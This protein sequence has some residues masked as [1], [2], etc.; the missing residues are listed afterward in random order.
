MTNYVPYRCGNKWGYMD[1]SG[2]KIIEAKYDS[3][4]LFNKGFAVV[5]LKNRFGLIDTNGVLILPLKFEEVNGYNDE[6]DFVR[7]RKK[8]KWNYYNKNGQKIRVRKT[9][10]ATVLYDCVSRGF[11]SGMA[12][13]YLH[14]SNGKYGFVKYL[15]N[16]IEEDSCKILQE[17]IYTDFLE[18]G[19]DYLALEGNNGWNLYDYGGELIRDLKITSIKKQP[20]GRR[21]NQFYLFDID[22]KYGLLNTE[23]EVIVE[24]KY[25]SIT[26]R[27]EDFYL[28]SMEWY[29]STEELFLVTIANDYFYIDQ[30][31][32]EYRCME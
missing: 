17:P 13:I 25:D 2:L 1:R 31:G 19:W 11:S 30:N 8:N 5:G 23:G 3:V 29:W 32:I 6:N 28:Q 26:E 4:S 21:G 14:E 22:S 27:K 16:N 9:Q 10:T 18:I 20:I 24:P 7:A 15:C 12:H